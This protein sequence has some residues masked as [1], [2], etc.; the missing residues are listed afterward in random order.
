MTVSLVIPGCNAEATLRRCLESV[1]PLLDDGSL[2]Q[3][4]FVDDGSTDRT[5]EIARNYPVRVLSGE[6]RGG[7]GA[8]RNRGWRAVDSEFVWFID[9]DCV[10]E[11]QALSRLLERFDRA[12]VGAVGGSYSNLIEDR[13]SGAW[14]ARAVHAEIIARH[15]AMPEQVDFLGSFNVVYRRNVLEEVDGFDEQLFNAP[16][17]P[18]SED[19]E[20]AYRLDDRGYVLEFDASSRVGHHHPTGLWGYL[21]RQAGQGFWRVP[22][23]AH[24]PDRASGD[25][26]SGAIDHVQPPL[27]MLALASTPLLVVPGVRWAS[28]ALY[29]LLALAQL[30]L[31]AR[32]IRQERS[33]RLLSF[34]PLSFLRSIARGL[35]L[36]RGVL[37]VSK[38]RAARAA[39]NESS[40]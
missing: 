16:G 1:V 18:G 22:L 15:R 24:Y 2:E 40:G 10:A 32:L 7:P 29:G 14:L 30:P 8:A 39:A 34:G 20:L 4:V 11:P 35:G 19:V 5:L 36:T 6:A 9:S 21:R 13:A 3:I 26:Y 33:A 17:S 25:S 38:W 23:Y 37:A 28:V 31:T 12:E 27:A